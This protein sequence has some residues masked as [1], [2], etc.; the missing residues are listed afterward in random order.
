MIGSD[1]AR[2]VEAVRQVWEDLPIEAKAGA[3]TA[4][5]LSTCPLLQN[6]DTVAKIYGTINGNEAWV[7]TVGRKMTT[8]VEQVRAGWEVVARYG[9]NNNIVKLRRI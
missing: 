1:Q 7:V 9:Y 4:G 6:E 3:Y 8:Y 2:C 5:H